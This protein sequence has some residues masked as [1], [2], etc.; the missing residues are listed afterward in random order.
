[1]ADFSGISQ[2]DPHSDPS[3]LA[4]RWKDWLQRF[5]RSLVAF[6]VK[7]KS[8]Q[9]ALLLYLA[10]PEV[11]KIF[12]TLPET[13]EDS[14]YEKAEEKLTAYFSPKKNTL[15][16]RYVFR[17]A[18]QEQNETI[19]QFHTRL[20]HLSATCDFK[21]ADE[22][23]KTQLVEHCTSSR[24]RRKAF[25]EEV[26]LGDLL[27]YARSLE[28]SD[29]HTKEVEKTIKDTVNYHSDRKDHR[30]QRSKPKSQ[31]C[32]KCGGFYPHKDKPCPAIGK[33]CRKCSRVGHFQKMCLS[34]KEFST[35]PNQRNVKKAS[36]TV[37]AM[38]RE[39]KPSST[40]L[41]SEESSSSS[42]EASFA[43]AAKGKKK[44]APVAKLKIEGATVDFL[45]DTGST[46]NLLGDEQFAKICK[47]ADK[48]IELI[49]T[50]AKIYA[51][52]SQETLFLKGKF[53][54]DVASKNQC[55]KAT[56]YVTKTENEKPSLLSCET[57]AELGLI[58]L[59][60]NAV[61]QTDRSANSQHR[62]STNDNKDTL[63]AEHMPDIEAHKQT[64]KFL[65]DKHPA[66]F[67]GIG[68]LQGHEQK[69]HV[70][71]SVPPVAQ[72]YRRVPF[73]LRKQLDSWLEDYV[74]KDIIEPVQDDSTEWV[75]GLVVAPKPKHPSEVRV[76]GDYRLVNTAVK[77]MRHPIPNVEELLENMAGAVKFSK[78]DLK[79][80]YHQILLE[81]K[82]RK[83]T[84]FTT[85]RGLY[86]YKRL[87]FGINSASEVFQS[88]IEDALR[89]IPGVRNIADDIIIWGS[90]QQEHDNRLQQLMQRLE[91]KQLT[92]NQDKC[93]FNQTHL[94]FYG[95]YFS[96]KGLK[97]DPEKVEAIKFAKP[98]ESVKELRSFLGLANYCARF[99][100]N[101]STIAAP[102]RA[103]TVK[104]VEFEWTDIQQMAFEKIKGEIAKDCTMAYYN[105]Q[106]KTVVTVD[107]S[108]VGL[109]GILSN[110]DEK[111]NVRNVAFA[112]RSLTP[113]EQ[114]YSQVEREALAVVW[115][116]EKFH[117][118]L[119]GTKFDIHSDNKALE[120]IYSP[121]SK[122]PARV[123]RWAMR[124]QQ[125]D[126]VLH[127]RN[128]E[129][130][131]ADI[132][133]RQPLPQTSSKCG[134]ADQYVNFMETKSVP[135]S[136]SVDQISSETHNDKQLQEVS[137]CLKSGVWPKSCPYYSVRHELSET[138]NGVILRGTKIVM[139]KS[140]Q[141]QTLQLAHKGHQGIVKTKQLLRS[142]VWW[143]K[144]DKSAE[145]YV[146]QCHACQSLSHGDPPPP[147]QQT[148]MPDKAWSRLHVDF[149]GP[150]PTG[151]S[152]M[153]LIDAYSKFPIV[154]IL[155]STTAKTVI[156]R[157]E[158]IF[159]MH[160]IPEEIISDNGPPFDSA[161][162]G[163]YMKR[164]GINHH[165]VTPLW[166]QANG[167]AES[168]MRPLGKAIKAA[169][170]E[171]KDWREELNE[172]LLSYRTTPHSVT[173]VSPAELLFNRQLRTLI[174][175]VNKLKEVDYREIHKQAQQTVKIKQSKSKGYA[176][177]KR[178][179]KSS[180]INV[181]DEVLVKQVK[182]NKFSPRFNTEPLVVTSIKGTAV[183]AIRPDNSTITRNV[184][185]F[186]RFHRP[187]IQLSETEMADDEKDL[188]SDS[189]YDL[190][191]QKSQNTRQP[192]GPQRYPVRQRNRPHYYIN[193]Q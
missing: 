56:F 166:P 105:P 43:I 84:T 97:P 6:D 108:P 24:V 184:S 169:K 29:R 28:V 114:R 167:E 122:P 14:D 40:H 86:R 94:W 35:R 5:K 65:K 23:I 115:A 13:G 137:A 20:R 39:S 149:N 46:V 73:H 101:F 47:N 93:L 163:D 21:D 52:G 58:K 141:R 116:C 85:H 15:Y 80:G 27:T 150:Y 164:K 160:G 3:S 138:D 131:P 4:Q 10:G 130:N 186:K 49:K 17:Q 135:K 95:F 78:V 98:P 143:A 127:H 118:Y 181:G 151:E 107:A 92:V 156:S 75:S 134:V 133:S 59:Q 121:K 177:L 30:L 171:G 36:K 62:L 162:F 110:V 76:C 148:K 51:Y 183:T 55:V 72:T 67:Q 53:Q 8:R 19:D 189:D 11:E 170:I 175:S 9:R 136:M 91:D 61:N 31:V 182:R 57:S 132:L 63:R 128:G 193:E 117:L 2:F 146:R 26:S 154:E 16:E 41:L 187:P 83:V 124:L 88:A 191:C 25:R 172:F 71:E 99:L 152:L 126:F 104:N 112:S 139:P 48:P 159:A 180:D 50:N 173:G 66:V 69:I 96:D 190:T 140:L 54:A 74:E 161:E 178:R 22:E 12:A 45:V 89:G 18:C 70:D 120:I 176:D 60:L 119:I 157:L 34:K 123:E 77:R 38:N 174:P 113:V 188:E 100:P 109:G 44:Q 87:P 144:I 145:E 37:N 125:Y 155:K 33:E 147:L 103:L 82:S 168:F 42:D 111:G 68:K 153:V 81:E 32:F 102:L 158:R 64:L 185:H 7:S 179:A 106:Q 1:M 90:T 192:Q 165:R 142:K 129:G 79:A